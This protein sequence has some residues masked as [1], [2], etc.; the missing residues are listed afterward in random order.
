MNL[1][2]QLQLSANNSECI[3]ISDTTSLK[4]GD[5][6][7]IIDGPFSGLITTIHG[8]PDG[9]RVAVLMDILGGKRLLEFEATVLLPVAV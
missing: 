1:S 9:E 4:E 2:P 5:R 8:K 3:Q 6:V 7:E